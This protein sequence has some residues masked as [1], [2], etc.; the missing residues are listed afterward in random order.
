M[1]TISCPRCGY[2]FKPSEVYIMTEAERMVID[3]LRDLRQSP[4]APVSTRLIADFTGYSPRW[5]R[6]HMTN[7]CRQGV[8]CTPR[9]RHSGWV[10]VYVIEMSNHLM[11]HAQN[12]IMAAA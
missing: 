7:L 9:G 10:E 1:T 12:S 6:S 2:V 8:V 3:T 5:V 11:N 4:F